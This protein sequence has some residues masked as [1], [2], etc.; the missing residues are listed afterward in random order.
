MYI[1]S[2]LNKS[3]RVL[4]RIDTSTLW[5]NFWFDILQFNFYCLAV[6]YF[7]GVFCFVLFF[8]D[9]VSLYSPGCPGTHSI[10]QAGLKLRNP[11]ASASQVFGLKVCATTAQLLIGLLCGRPD[12][13]KPDLPQQPTPLEN[14]LTLCWEPSHPFLH[15]RLIMRTNWP[16]SWPD[17]WGCLGR[18]SI[19]R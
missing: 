16:L 13:R 3:I 4:K 14:Q 1:C 18:T 8:W 6:V 2:N 17:T 5:N 9:R 10:D 7:L 19:Q 11:P 15:T 12:C